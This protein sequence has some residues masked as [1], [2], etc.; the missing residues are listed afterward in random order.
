MMMGKGAINGW[1]FLYMPVGSDFD[2]SLMPT[3]E[4][5]LHLKE[6]IH[7]IR[8][9]IPL[10]AID[11]WGDAPFVGGCIAASRYI[12]INHKGDVEPCIFAHFAQANIKDTTLKEA[13]NCQYFKEIRKRQPYK[14]NLYL[15]CM[16]I[17]YPQVSRELY[18]CCNDI[19]ST[20]DNSER[21]LFEIK[22]EIDSYSK[23]VTCVYDKIWEK[24]KN[25]F[26]W[27]K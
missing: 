3:A 16:L 12:H 9:K 4:E 24:E 23:E 27:D 14:E 25:R 8:G 13:L 19:Y 22:D 21:L 15:P 6:S 26:N 17:D 11:F 2:I 20:D 5:R 18:S 7:Y 10:F 1:Y